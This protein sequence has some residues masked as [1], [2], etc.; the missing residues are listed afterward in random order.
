MNEERARL[1]SHLA[2]LKYR[3]ME[4]VTELDAAVR[5]VK[6]V[7]ADWSIREK[8]TVD[9]PGAFVHMERAL[10]QHAELRGLDAEIRRVEED[11]V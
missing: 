9:L 7:L 4:L 5:S 8:A 1:K 2:G 6:S 11:L 3:R 10:A